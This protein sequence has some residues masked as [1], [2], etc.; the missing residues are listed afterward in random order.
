MGTFNKKAFISE[1]QYILQLS[2]ALLKARGSNF[3]GCSTT[4]YK[5]LYLSGL[6]MNVSSVDCFHIL[7]VAQKEVFVLDF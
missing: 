7:A 6:R 1:L 5:T 2:A 4:D 3:T